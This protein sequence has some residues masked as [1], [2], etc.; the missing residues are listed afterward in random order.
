MKALRIIL[1]VLAVIALAVCIALI[2]TS[3]KQG[4]SPDVQ[5]NNWMQ[6]IGFIKKSAE[7]VTAVIGG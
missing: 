3:I 4:V 1:E 2:V 7:T 5:W 6:S